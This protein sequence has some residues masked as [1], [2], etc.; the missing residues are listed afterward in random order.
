MK[1]ALLGPPGVGKGT[2]AEALAKR[3]SIPHISTGDI[4]REAVSEGTELGRK[5][6]DFMGRGEL[7]PDD[8][9]VAM[10]AG[11]L[12]KEDCAR[13]WLLDGFPRSVGQADALDGRLGDEV[14]VVVCF[15][16]PEE[17]LVERL[18]GRRTCRD[19]GR[20]YHVEFSPPRIAGRCDHCGG[21][22]FQRDDDRPE[23]VRARL[24][25][26]NEQTASLIERYEDAGKL[27]RIDASGGP[28]EVAEQIRKASTAWE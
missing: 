6:K 9:V 8:L 1:L 27:V 25:T 22:F 16:A 24:R 17:T 10:I 19:C 21:E 26:Y 28:D 7:V 11:R 12:E 4:L 14:Y 15:D 23:T 13:G 5:A 2:Q 18:S 3:Y 20:I